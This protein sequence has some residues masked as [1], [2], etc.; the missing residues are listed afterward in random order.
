M[1]AQ[2]RAMEAFPDLRVIHE[3][4]PIAGGSVLAI[5]PG[6]KP[7]EHLGKP[8]PW[9]SIKDLAGYIAGQSDAHGG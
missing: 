7:R 6:C 3:Y 2:L 9:R 1:P 4:P 5:C 8:S